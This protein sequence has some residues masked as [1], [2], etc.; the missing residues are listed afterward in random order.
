MLLVSDPFVITIGEIIHI[1]LQII[2]VSRNLFCDKPGSAIWRSETSGLRFWISRL[3]NPTVRNDVGFTGMS[4]C[5]G[6]QT[7]ENWKNGLDHAEQTPLVP[8]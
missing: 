5:D 7:D 1:P 2:A 6:S 4:R 3:L 8:L